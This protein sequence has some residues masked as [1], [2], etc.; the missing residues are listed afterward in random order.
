MLT[1]SAGV[2][3][4]AT[5]RA[6]SA[7]SAA[8]VTYSVPAGPL[9]QALAVFGRQ[10]GLQVTYLAAIAAGKSS[11]GFT[12]PATPGQALARILNGTGLV[13]SF[14]NAGT[15]AIALPAT[16][17]A[18]AA[19]EGGLT[20][21]PILVDGRGETAWGPVRGIIAE[22][23]A[24]G[25]KTDTP[26][27]EI[28]QSISVVTAAQL[29][30]QGAQ[31]VGEAFRYTPGVD[32]E[33]YG[34]D[35]RFNHFTVRGFQID[36]FQF[37][38][39]LKFPAGGYAIPRIEPYGLERLEV[40]RGPS[41][42][43]YGQNVP[44]GMINLVSKRPTADPVHEVQIGSGYPARIQGAFDFSGA[45]NA[46]ETLLYRLVG[47]GSYGNTQV[48]HTI[49]QR[50]FLAP[51]FTYRPSYDTRLTILSHIQR[52]N[53]E[54]WSGTF[55]PMQGTLK[56]NP[57]GKIP[58]GTFVGEPGFDHYGRDPCPA[59]PGSSSGCRPTPPATPSSRSP[60]PVRSSPWRGPPGCPSP[61]CISTARRR[62]VEPA[63]R[64]GAVDALAGGCA[65]VPVVSK[66]FD[67]INH[68][69]RG[70]REGE[71]DASR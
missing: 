7:Q 28:P 52:D 3:A 69:K 53:V 61:G 25:S 17:S 37:V 5:E 22:R 13:Y 19:G 1:V 58:L 63:P 32:S 62:D 10:A 67:I 14:T 15:V 27:I 45:A 42:G 6:A 16:G 71:F 9:S 18:P 50:L 20:L 12:G 24:T 43:L 2:G 34:F 56:S 46:D 31:T 30:E 44:G 57:N 4:V 8:E 65:A 21:D 23:S 11:P 36:K 60:M 40:L 49:D 66:R 47:A 38:D 33:A 41:S 68:W 59:S 48:D 29:R 35:A 39:G 51:S 70:A 26:I 54:G 64:R 55:L